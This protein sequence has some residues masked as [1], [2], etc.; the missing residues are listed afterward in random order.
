[1]ARKI[2]RHEPCLGMDVLNKIIILTSFNQ[3]ELRLDGHKSRCLKPRLANGKEPLDDELHSLVDLTL[4]EY[5]PE[6]LKDTAT[7]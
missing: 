3:I 4:V 5:R 2:P 7:D 6:P 1:M